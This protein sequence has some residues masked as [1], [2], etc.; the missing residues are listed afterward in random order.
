M[1]EQDEQDFEGLKKGMSKSEV[2]DAG[3]IGAA[4]SPIG[5]G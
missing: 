3:V 1:D 5:R 4:P 2:E